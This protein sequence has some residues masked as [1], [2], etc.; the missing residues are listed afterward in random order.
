[1]HV[2]DELVGV[3]QHGDTLVVGAARVERP[4]FYRIAAVE[5]TVDDN[6]DSRSVLAEHGGDFLD[7]GPVWM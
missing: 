6:V 7:S 2:L 5:K 4:L 1:M 3:K